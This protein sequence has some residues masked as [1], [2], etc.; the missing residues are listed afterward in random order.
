MIRYLLSLRKNDETIGSC[1]YFKLKL[2]EILVKN[3]GTSNE[4]VKS[5]LQTLT[6]KLVKSFD[7]IML[8]NDGVHISDI[9]K[10]LF[11]VVIKDLAREDL[12]IFLMQELQKVFK[13]SSYNN[14]MC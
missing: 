13:K 4:Q 9:L 5:A 3:Y 6:H 12:T 14:L 2:I 1:I 11:K 10:L 7:Y 8:S